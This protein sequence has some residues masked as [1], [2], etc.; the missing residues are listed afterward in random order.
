MVRMSEDGRPKYRRNKKEIEEVSYYGEDTIKKA[1]SMKKEDVCE[2]INELFENL[3]F[4]TCQ[5]M[6]ISRNEAERLSNNNKLSYTDIPGLLFYGNSMDSSL[7][8]LVKCL[9]D[10]KRIM[11]PLE[12]KVRYNLRTLYELNKVAKMNLIGKIKRDGVVMYYV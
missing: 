8:K 11:S 6:R 5:S 9:I 4:V 1:I 2:F 3:S 10:M 12:A 7:Y